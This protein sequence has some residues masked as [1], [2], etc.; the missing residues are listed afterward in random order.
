M[1]AILLTQPNK[2]DCS[3][4]VICQDQVEKLMFCVKTEDSGLI[5]FFLN[6]IQI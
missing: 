2:I 3:K 5:S 6:N 1:L 4:Y